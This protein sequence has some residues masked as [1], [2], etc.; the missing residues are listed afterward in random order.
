M[1]LNLFERLVL[2]A[3]ATVLPQEVLACRLLSDKLFL[4]ARNGEIDS[5]ESEEIFNKIE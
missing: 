5:K 1:K 2:L 3:L 4:F